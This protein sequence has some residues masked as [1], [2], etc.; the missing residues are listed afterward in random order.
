MCEHCVAHVTTA[1][2]GVK[3]VKGVRVSLD[4]GTA[5]VDAGLLV[6]DKALVAAVEEAGYK[7]TV[8]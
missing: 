1:L 3:G 2:E 6:S 4:D 8:A 7:A 5:E